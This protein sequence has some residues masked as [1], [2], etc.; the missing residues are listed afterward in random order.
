[1]EKI[2]E[3]AYRPD[4]KHDFDYNSTYFYIV[5]EA[6]AV[7]LEVEDRVYIKNGRGEQL[8]VVIDIFDATDAQYTDM[9]KAAVS[10]IR[11]AKID[12]DEILQQEALAEEIRALESKMQEALKEIEKEQKYKMLAE[13]NPI[14]AEIYNSYISKRRAYCKDILLDSAKSES[15]D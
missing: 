13:C 15:V 9:Y 10:P 14:Y 4:Y 8:G 6:Q 12:L 3:L 11:F 1:M 2:I 5:P 7:G